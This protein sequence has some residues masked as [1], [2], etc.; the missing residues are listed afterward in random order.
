M[1]LVLCTACQDV[2]RLNLAQR[3][4]SCGKTGGQ[5]LDDI[6]AQYWGDKAVPLG[7]SN[8]SLILALQTQKNVGDKPDGSGHTFTAFVIP[9]SCLSFRRVQKAEVKAQKGISVTASDDESS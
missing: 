9:E 4:C 2:V 7:F 5:Y 8:G 3:T 1:K 6:N